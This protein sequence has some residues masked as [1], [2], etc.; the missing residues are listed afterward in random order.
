MR[1]FS[2]R[3]IVFLL[4][5]LFSCNFPKKA[6]YYYKLENLQPYLAEITPVKR[7][8]GI[9]Y[10]ISD[11]LNSGG[12]LEI[13]LQPKVSYYYKSKEKDYS[14]GERGAEGSEEKID[15]IRFFLISIDNDTI[16]N[17]SLKEVGL[18]KI[19]DINLKIGVSYTYSFEGDKGRERDLDNID[20]FISKFNTPEMPF[21]YDHN[22][23]KSFRFKFEIL[24]EVK[25]GDYKFEC[26]VY[27]EN[28]RVAKSFRKIHFQ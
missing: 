5:V 26:I 13:L 23:A 12:E 9:Y 6:Y 7:S 27:F 8:D 16:N 1:T 17:F 3:S 28:G 10:N 4:T 18:Y 14:Y 25:P 21:I 2:S 11:T 22:L 20:E 24:Q 15:T 19:D